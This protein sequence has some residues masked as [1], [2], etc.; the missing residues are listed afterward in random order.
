LENQ[1]SRLLGDKLKTDTEFATALEERER[2]QKQLQKKID[3]CMYT[4]LTLTVSNTTT[5]NQRCAGIRS[6]TRKNQT[7]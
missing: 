6:T 4:I 2:G 1:V 5:Q 7:S 3:E